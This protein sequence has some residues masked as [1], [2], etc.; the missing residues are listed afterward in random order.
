MQK[1][2]RITLLSAVL[3]SL[4]FASGSALADVNN[5]IEDALKIGKD[6]GVKVDI[7]YRYENV[8]Q[9]NTINTTTG[10]PLPATNQ[11]QTANA[12][13]IRTRLGILTPSFMGVQGF[14]E[15]S[16]THVLQ[17][18]YNNGVTYAPG[19]VGN[20]PTFS[21][22]PDPRVNRLNQLW[23]SYSGIPDTVIKGGRQR[24]KLDDDRFIGNVPWR[25]NE[26]IFDG[27][28][29]ANKSIKNLTA[30]VGYLGN[31]N[32][33]LGVDDKLNAPLLNLNYDLSDY[34][35]L[36]GYGYWLGYTHQPLTTT[37]NKSNQTYGIRFVNS[38]KPHK[39]FDHY[40]LLYTAEWSLQKDYLN[41][42]VK[43]QA[44]RFNLMAGFSAYN[45]KFQG[46]MEQLDGHGIN[47]TFVTPLGSAHGING[48]SDVLNTTPAY[49]M[50]H[51]SG[52]V[53]STFFDDDSLEVMGVF[54]DFSSSAG[55][56]NYG[57]EWDFQVQQKFGKHYSVLAKYAYF[58]AAHG[59]NFSPN[60]TDTQ[61]VWVQGNISF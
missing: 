19:V 38:D 7:R 11:P 5:D 60:A 49:G 21:T 3:F 46:A 25:Q 53:A 43:Y 26:Q 2:Q 24:I 4:T 47:Q 42:P 48:W 1:N 35:H 10:L 32:T 34:G 29:V 54:H 13:T 15:Y 22:I 58:N 55:K 37:A 27:V 45:V 33:V 31:V 16:G 61:K 56:M 28:L 36:V 14:V 8:N 40:S 30:T 18:D 57:K 52:T 23:L 41:S 44:D 17:D 50:R 39:F 9:Y 12:N 59:A 6:G 51:W 20:R